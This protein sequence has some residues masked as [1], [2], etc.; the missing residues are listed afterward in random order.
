MEI[1]W[2][3]PN[4]HDA[5]S[6]VCLV[7]G[8]PCEP[9]LVNGLA[10]TPIAAT[11]TPPVK[12]TDPQAT[13][14]L[15]PGTAPAVASPTICIPGYQILSELGRGGMGVVY[16]ARHLRLDCIVAL[17]M[18]LAGSHAGE[19]EVQRFR[20]EAQ[21]VAKLRH[22]H[23]VQVYDVG[24]ADG[25]HYLALEFVDG[26]SLADRLRQGPLEPEQAASLLAALARGV[27][28]AHQHGIVHRDLKP[29]NV[30]LAN[31][32]REPPVPSTEGA[33]PPLAVPKITDFGLAKQLSDSAL[34]TG[35]GAIMG[36]PSYMPP[37]QASGKNSEVGPAS[38]VYALGAIL[39]ECI[40]GRPPFTGDTPLETILKLGAE[41]VTP[42]R[43]LTPRCPRN[44][45]TICLK[46]LEKSPRKRYASALE[47]AE[48]LDRF[49][50]GEPIL[51]RPVGPV[52]RLGRWCARQPA[53]AT[54]WIGLAVLYCNHLLLLV[55]GLEGEGG[56]YHWF[57]T[58]LLVL[59]ASGAWC[60][61]RLS[62]SVRW[63]ALSGVAWVS[64]DVLCFT[65]L[66]WRGHGGN[67]SLVTGYLLMIAG[68]ALRSLPALVWYVAG[69]CIV[70]YLWLVL[71]LY[72]IGE[73]ASVPPHR[74][75]IFVL[76]QVIMALIGW[77]QLR[78]A[79]TA[80]GGV[81]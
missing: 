29:G 5:F 50:A 58:S 33:R 57:V 41:E 6:Q 17:K 61:Q 52:G 1:R 25:Q 21:S 10:P 55:A 2:N 64:F 26:G 19:I 42:P 75:V 51:A 23:I 79:R 35:T 34:K 68:A 8:A 28:H 48:D 73:G 31:A 53:L 46:C 56:S 3:C 67:S 71:H 77:L 59:W 43:R 47:L 24:E 14:P 9:C 78:R 44:L 13:I 70:G 20:V 54:T 36:T 76:F 38:D 45:E 30:L 18:I 37:E 40:T 81:T 12:D 4:G 7:C 72:L 49:L 80:T 16:K 11:L 65:V 32:G 22:P 63:R 39:Y 69:L 15:T 60:F 27:D 74:A 66:L 62:R